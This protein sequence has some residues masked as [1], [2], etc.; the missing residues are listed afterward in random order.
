MLTNLQSRL[1]KAG[2]LLPVA[3][4]PFAAHAQFN[5]APG[6]A[7]NTTTTYTDLGTTGTAITTAN[8]DDDNS[9]AQSIGFNF[10]F[11][12]VTFTDFVLNTN[13]LIR[14]GSVAPSVAAAFPAYA[15]APET[16]PISGTNAADVNL[17]A[18]FNLDLGPGSAGGTEYRVVTTGTAPN[19]VCTIQWKN[20]ADKPQAAASTIST[21]I[22]TQLA[23]M[24]FQ[25]K[26]Y[27]TTNNIEFV[28]GA[29]VAGTGAAN[30]KYA[31]VGIKG[32]APASSVV[33]TKGSSALWSTTTFLAGPYLD[34]LLGNGHNVRQ[35]FLPDAG[36]T[37]RFVPGAAPATCA[38][39]TSA[40][41]GNATNNSLQI[42]FTPGAGNVSYN[43]TYTAA[44]GTTQTLTPA[45]TASPITISGLT[46][47]TAYTVTLQS[48]CAG[49]TTGALLTGSATTTGG[50]TVPAPANDD[51]TGA[52]TLSLSATCTPTNGT[53]AGATTTGGTTPS[54]YAN[55]G[56]GI[57]ASP[58]DV[59]FKFTTAAT[60]IGSTDASIQVT[61]TTAGQ[62][63]VFS[64]ATSAGPFTQVGCA[65]GTA[66]NTAAGP[67]R[68]SA[69]TPNTTY[70]VFVSGYG[71]AD[72]QGAFTICAVGLA[73][74]AP[75]TYATLPY[76]ES[77][78]GPWTSVLGTNDVP[79]VNWRNTPVTGDNSWRREDD[80]F[81]SAGWQYAANEVPTANFPTP[82]YVTRFSTGAH[83]ARFHSFGSDEDALGAL[84]LYVDM[85]GAGNKTL[86][87]DYINPTGDD[88]LK[89]FLST[90]GGATFNATPL[91]QLNTSTT[92]SAVQPIII[93]STSATTVI[94]FQA[95]SDF[96]NDD[97]GIDN[98]RIAVVTATQNAALAAT[99]S[100]YPN[101][102][103][104]SFQ[105]TVPAAL[106]AASAQLTNALG[107]VV[108]TRQLN[109]P[110]AGGTADFNVSGLAA[111]VYSL[112][113]KSGNDLVVKRVVVE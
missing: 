74:P 44:G 32:S 108:Q 27:E 35:T 26:L 102:A 70:Y 51:P 88:S 83:S 94:R 73:T 43:V 59:W 45:P 112:Q 13:G 105:L 21:V 24:S 77:F 63:R 23:N 49:G 20:V 56:C 25:V 38:D 22:T 76:T 1:K 87:F 29:A 100:L 15:Q 6:N 30:A 103:H 40:T 61:G 41:I 80:G 106:H 34:P 64:A 93:N 39:P 98:L 28:Y 75:P 91:R 79:T 33:A 10:S 86:T 9:A 85:S 46:A 99:M 3:L 104:Q 81:T 2:R 67:L 42:A 71:S 5:Y 58:K 53:N 8:N 57:A 66:N 89:V 12:G 37:Y 55:P 72:T 48:V 36:R 14:L 107:Q 109:L 78:E 60:G 113:L 111:G 54:G 11:N 52:I 65:A 69:L 16:G 7:V 101:P 31:A 92:F 17:I 18:P 110:V 90:N 19:R 4:L 47:G 95:K 97:I 84:D 82:P 50:T 62:V 68:L 96:G